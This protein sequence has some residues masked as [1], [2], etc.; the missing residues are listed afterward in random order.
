MTSAF[1]TLTGLLADPGVG[2][3]VCAVDLLCKAHLLSWA[4]SS[5]PVSVTGR[6]T[7]TGL[8][9]SSWD[10]SLHQGLP[11]ARQHPVDEAVSPEEQLPRV[12]APC[13]GCARGRLEEMGDSGCPS[14]PTRC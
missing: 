2:V 13:L 1:W 3:G 4:S 12:R 7:F 14:A 10:L 11:G 6:F 8:S 9:L 5:H